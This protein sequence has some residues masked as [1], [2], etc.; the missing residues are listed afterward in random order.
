MI[1]LNDH[2][3]DELGQHN[4]LLTNKTLKDEIETGNCSGLKHAKYIFKLS[5]DLNIT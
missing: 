3:L 1:D 5:F 2:Q 4:L